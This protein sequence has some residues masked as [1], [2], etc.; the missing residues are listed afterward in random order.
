MALIISGN[1]DIDFCFTYIAEG[2][3][4]SLDTVELKEALSGTPVN[5]LKVVKYLKEMINENIE[6]LRKTSLINDKY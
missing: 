2:N 4:W 6:E 3:Q 5:D 1:P